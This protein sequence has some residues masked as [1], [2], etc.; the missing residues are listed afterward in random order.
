MNEDEIRRTEIQRCKLIY[1]RNTVRRLLK[2]R[3]ADIKASTGIYDEVWC[4]YKDDLRLLNKLIREYDKFLDDQGVYHS[5]S[6]T[7]EDDNAEQTDQV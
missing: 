6:H 4:K 1:T 2:A 3:E 5:N 7:E